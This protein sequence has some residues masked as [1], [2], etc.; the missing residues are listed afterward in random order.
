MRYD[1]PDVPMSAV[2][3][4]V[5]VVL[6]IVSVVLLEGLYFHMSNAEFERKIVAPPNEELVQM[7]V[8]QGELLEGY[9]WVDQEAAVVRIPIERAM[10]L[11]VEEAGG[12]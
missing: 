6:V 9:A 2:V 7:R 12:E 3:A 5:S 4:V 1:D 10:K 11:V 8:E